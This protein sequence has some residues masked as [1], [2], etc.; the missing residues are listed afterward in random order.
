[1]S[2]FTKR[3]IQDFINYVE[4]QVGVDDIIISG[5]GHFSIKTKNPLKLIAKLGLNTHI[6]SIYFEDES[7]NWNFFDIVHTVLP[8]V[9]MISSNGYD[10]ELVFAI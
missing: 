8:T 10:T 2:K 1:M 3:Q 4:Q 9:Q 6:E 5:L 7:R